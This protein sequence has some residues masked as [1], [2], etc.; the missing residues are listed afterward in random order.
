METHEAALE[1]NDQDNKS[2]Q[3][4]TMTDPK[5]FIIEL[6]G[7]QA[8]AIESILPKGH[9]LQVEREVKPKRVNNKKKVGAT[10]K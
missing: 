9:C 5:K 6:T 3:N 7:S 2:K 1:D 10:K 4:N 8:N